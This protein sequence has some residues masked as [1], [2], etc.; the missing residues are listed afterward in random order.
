MIL[1]AIGQRSGNIDFIDKFLFGGYR[2]FIRTIYERIWKMNSKLLNIF[3]IAL[4]ALLLST[5]AFACPGASQDKDI[6]KTDQ[7]MSS[8]SDPNQSNSTDHDIGYTDQGNF[9]T[10][11]SMG[12][13]DQSEA[14]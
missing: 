7:S 10:E 9:S 4:A 11:N 5:Q 3:V 2:I 14:D 6:G 12:Q 1:S 13:S 8:M